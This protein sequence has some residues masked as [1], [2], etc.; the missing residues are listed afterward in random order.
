MTDTDGHREQVKGARGA[1]AE[2]LKHGGI[3]EC[4]TLAEL[5]H[6]VTGKGLQV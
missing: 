5:F 2:L 4:F 1:V 3:I 6:E